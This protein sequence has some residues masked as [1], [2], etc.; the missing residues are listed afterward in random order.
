MPPDAVRKVGPEHATPHLYEGSVCLVETGPDL[1]VEARAQVLRLW[2]QARV[3]GVDPDHHDALP[4]RTSH[5]PH[6]IAPPWPSSPRAKAPPA[7]SLGTASG[8]TGSPR[9]PGNVADITLTNGPRS[10]GL[11]A[12][13]RQID[14]FLDAGSPDPDALLDLFNAKQIRARIGSGRMKGCFITF[15]GVEA[16]ENPRRSPCS[17]TTSRRLPRC[18]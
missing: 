18:W 11:R 6:I 14:A 17:P 16:A 1:D 15:E 2:S 3:I 8:P 10:C 12:V 5:V 13:Q 9:Q 7:I 4:A